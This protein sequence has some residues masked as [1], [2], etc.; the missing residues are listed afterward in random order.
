MNKT[1]IKECYTEL[2]N[3]LDSALQ[4]TSGISIT[5][6]EE[7]GELQNIKTTLAEINEK[8]KA[9]IDSLEHNSEWNKLCV[10]FF[11]ETNA[12]K[13]TIIESLRII[14][15]EKNR[16]NEIVTAKENLNKLQKQHE[17]ELSELTQK[18]AQLN[19]FLTEEKNNSTKRTLKKILTVA[20]IFILGFLSGI[21][22]FGGIFIK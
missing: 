19:S 1:E 10:A 5:G 8:F 20:V 15:D 14:Y 3:T 9:E 13:S 18:L 11:G 2:K 7:Q 12:G 22:I 16:R 4:E 6:E 21:G 17:Q